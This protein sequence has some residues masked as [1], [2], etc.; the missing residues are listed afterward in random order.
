MSRCVATRKS[1]GRCTVGAIGKG[2][3]CLFHGPKLR[4]KGKR[5]RKYGR[6]RR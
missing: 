5:Q 4:G 2:K 6:R 3:R 1:G